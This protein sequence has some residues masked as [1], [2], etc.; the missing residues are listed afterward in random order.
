M[1]FSPVLGADILCLVLLLQYIR[2]RVALATL[3][4][5]NVVWYQD[6]R[7]LSYE[8]LSRAC[9]LELPG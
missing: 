2:L 3:Q 4:A 7:G 6:K 9:L 8:L 5:L 1:L